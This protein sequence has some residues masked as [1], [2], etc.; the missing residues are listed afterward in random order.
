[1]KVNLIGAW[2]TT[3]Y[4]CVLV[5][6]SQAL[7]ELGCSVCFYPAY[8]RPGIV[9]DVTVQ[10]Y[11]QLWQKVT[12]N[13][14]DL[15]A[16]SLKIWH[17]DQLDWRIGNGLS[18][19]F[20]FF[21]LDTLNQKEIT[22]MSS[23]DVQFVA[24][25]WAN[26]ILLKHNINNGVV[27]PLG[28]DRNI[29][30]PLTEDYR[31]EL[32]NRIGVAMDDYIFYMSGKFEVRK[33][34]DIILDI[35]R[36]AFPTEN[37]VK[38]VVNSWSPNLPEVNNSEWA[39]MLSQDQRVIVLRNRF[40][41]QMEIAKL[42]SCVDCCVYPSKAEGWNL[43]ALEALAMHKPVIIN[44]YSAHTEFSDFCTKVEPVGMELAYDGLFFFGNGRWS[45]PDKKKFAAEMRR[46]YA[47]KI[48]VNVNAAAQKF[49]WKN[50]ATVILNTLKNLQ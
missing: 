35:F 10:T 12:Q 45:I 46:H 18:A 19:A 42:V 20:S 27:A 28:V 7:T 4:G 50:T 9:E 6:L 39:S 22:H 47:N 37:D 8:Q 2:N 15:Y 14:V 48:N 16:P 21:E 44:N 11:S 49:S 34:H 31:R 40:P 41:H 5:N 29:F 25:K 33:G 23:Q 36:E 1:M 30:Y 17:Q 38:L 26:Q 3:S 32:C 43:P 24:S 13:E